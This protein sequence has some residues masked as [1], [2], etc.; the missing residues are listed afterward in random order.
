[1]KRELQPFGFG[2]R[3]HVSEWGLM[4]WR[5]RDSISE[6]VNPDRRINTVRQPTKY[7]RRNIFL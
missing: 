5:A 3:S 1:M 4:V 2:K 6:W 7:D